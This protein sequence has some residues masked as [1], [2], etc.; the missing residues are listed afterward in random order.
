MGTI[1]PSSFSELVPDEK[2]ILFCGGS[3]LE[4]SQV[5]EGKRPTELAIFKKF[6]TNVFIFFNI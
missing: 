4:A 2:N 3:T 5:L 1:Y 6:I